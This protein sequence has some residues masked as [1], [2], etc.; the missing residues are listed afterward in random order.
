MS[1]RKA[2]GSISVSERRSI[3]NLASSPL[4]NAGEISQH[5]LRVQ[6]NETY[7]DGDRAYR[8]QSDRC[9]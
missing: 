7:V 6:G 1:S 5:S 9:R 8:V 3:E 2:N 4:S